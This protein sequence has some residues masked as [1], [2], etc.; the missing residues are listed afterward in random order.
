MFAKLISSGVNVPML[1]LPHCV[2]TGYTPLIS[3]GHGWVPEEGKC[4][5]GG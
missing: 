3:C 4:R 2:S 5:L 1:P